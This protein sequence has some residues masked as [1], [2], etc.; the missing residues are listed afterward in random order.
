MLVGLKTRVREREREG[1]GGEGN[2]GERRK[3]TEG[4]R[5]NPLTHKR[6]GVIRRCSLLVPFINRILVKNTF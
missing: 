3:K 4:H 1:G 5:E 2:G 6:K